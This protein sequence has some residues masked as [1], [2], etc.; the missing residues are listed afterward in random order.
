MGERRVA[1]PSPAPGPCGRT[2]VLFQAVAHQTFMAT[3]TSSTSTTAT[4]AS[5]PLLARCSSLSRTMSVRDPRR[6]SWPH[7]TRRCA[8]SMSAIYFFSFRHGCR[9]YHFLF[10]RPRVRRARFLP[11]TRQCVPAQSPRRRWPLPAASASCRGVRGGRANALPRLAMRDDVVR[12]AMRSR[13]SRSFDGCASE[14]RLERRARDGRAR[15]RF[16]WRCAH[17]VHS[18][19][20]GSQDAAFN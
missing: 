9:R 3:T 17:S 14:M 8:A 15:A 1:R 12:D 7:P 11:S 18:A 13:G 5:C 16:L 10:V 4:S 20:T 6:P 2:T 19:C